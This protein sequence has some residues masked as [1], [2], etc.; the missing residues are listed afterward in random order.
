MDN[1]KLRRTLT[2]KRTA[3]GPFWQK[4]TVNGYW[5]VIMGGEINKYTS[6]RQKM[7]REGWELFRVLVLVERR[8]E[9][10]HNH[11]MN[12]YFSLIYYFACADCR[13]VHNLINI[14][15]YIWGTVLELWMRKRIFGQEMNKTDNGMERGKHLLPP[16]IYN[17][18]SIPR[19]KLLLPFILFSPF[20][21]QILYILRFFCNFAYLL[22]EYSIIEI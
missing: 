13:P 6:H 18:H 21:D 20:S 16:F 7:E 14:S 22:S 2:R 5:G 1:A 19:K 11:W 8:D 3:A 15:N 17:P 9:D 12:E 4:W 10:T